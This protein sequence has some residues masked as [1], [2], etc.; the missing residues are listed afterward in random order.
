MHC[1]WIPAPAD[2][3]KAVSD[4]DYYALAGLIIV[5][6]NKMLILAKR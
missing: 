5:F 3:A 4:A 6:K 2:G 1:H